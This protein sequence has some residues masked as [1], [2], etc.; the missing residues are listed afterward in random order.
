MS[1]TLT[2]MTIAGFLIIAGAVF[3][4]PTVD[5]ADLKSLRGD[6]AVDEANTA[7]ELFNV[8]EGAPQAR[9][10]RQQPPLIPHR[11]DKYEIDLKVNQCLRCHD[12]PY[13]VEENAP[14]ISET[15]YE[16]REGK[17]LDFVA[18]TRW[19]CNQCHV[20]QVDA[21]ALVENEFRPAILER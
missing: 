9:A 10:F 13:N 8:T 19:F 16:S 21:P 6:T 3:A 1:K 12:W 15:H 5:A 11:V 20:P 4:P 2:A 14:K 17:R 18:G 7:P